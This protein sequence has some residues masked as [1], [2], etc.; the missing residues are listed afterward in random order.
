MLLFSVFTNARNRAAILILGLSLGAA[1]MP[2]GGLEA[3]PDFETQVS[4]LSRQVSGA[5]FAAPDEEL[6]PL[7]F[8][9]MTLETLIAAPLAEVWDFYTLSNLN[10]VWDDSLIRTRRL[11]CPDGQ[12]SYDPDTVWPDIQPGLQLHST[13]KWG[14]AP[15]RLDMEIT[16]VEPGQHTEFV[17]MKTAPA[18]GTQRMIFRTERLSTGE[19][20]T[21]VTHVS[22]YR[23]KN[24]A[25]HR[26][27]PRVHRAIFDPM[28]E[29]ARFYLESAARSRKS[30]GVPAGVR[31]T[32]ACMY[33][34]LHLNLTG[35]L[36]RS[37]AEVAARIDALVSALT[38]NEAAALSD[39]N[40]RL[41]RE[42]DISQAARRACR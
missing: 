32:A 11:V 5:V 28:H 25:F 40:G 13:L 31:E 23:G 24:M 37:E 12:R 29:G 19:E 38:Q 15:V 41:E 7:A 26:L 4:R 20:A 39:F 6:A 30:C 14:E 22:R 9:V 17:Y 10:K 35:E 33:S 1:A 3:E 18:E 21:R 27:Y 36:P 8:D 16:T 34:R 2:A 42:E